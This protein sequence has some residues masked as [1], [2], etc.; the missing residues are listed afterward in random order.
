MKNL[1]GNFGVIEFISFPIGYDFLK[2][3]GHPQIFFQSEKM[4]RLGRLEKEEETELGQLEFGR[5]NM[6]LRVQ[7]TIDGLERL[8]FWNSDRY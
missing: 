2:V 4:E 8:D 5:S 1:W 7:R 6:G 3:K